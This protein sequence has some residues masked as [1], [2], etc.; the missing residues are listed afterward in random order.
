MPEQFRIIAAMEGA[1]ECIGHPTRN[2]RPIPSLVSL[3]EPS[4]IV[5]KN[6]LN[7]NPTETVVIL[8]RTTAEDSRVQCNAEGHMFEYVFEYGIVRYRTV[9]MVWSVTRRRIFA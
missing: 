8:K 1:S 2:S 5:P 9:D 4:N 7:S 3:N 6:A